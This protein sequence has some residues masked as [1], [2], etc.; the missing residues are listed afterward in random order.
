MQLRNK[1]MITRRTGGTFTSKKSQTIELGPLVE[2]DSIT[3]KTRDIQSRPRRRRSRPVQPLPLR[4]PSSTSVGRSYHQSSGSRTEQRYW[5]SLTSWE[6]AHEVI[7]F[8]FSLHMGC[9]SSHETVRDLSGGGS[10]TR[11]PGRAAGKG[12][13]CREQQLFR[14][15]P[16]FTLQKAI[17]IASAEL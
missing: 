9:S 4:A 16:P 13:S 3:R 1:A 12:T 8:L 14:A 7:C 10:G 15:Q 5:A 11:Q 2:L 6:H 17:A